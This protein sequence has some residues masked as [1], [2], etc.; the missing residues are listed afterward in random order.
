MKATVEIITNHI[1]MV[2][3][4]LDRLND[5][6]AKMK[7]DLVW[8]IVNCEGYS[9]AYM[10]NNASILVKGASEISVNLMHTRRL[11]ETLLSILEEVESK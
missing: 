8:S 5:L 11:K 10:L 7:K 9:D 6:M 1:K 2:N 3:K 4:E